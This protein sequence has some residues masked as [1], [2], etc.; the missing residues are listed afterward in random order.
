MNLLVNN[1]IRQKLLE[2]PDCGKNA[3]MKSM[4]MNEQNGNWNIMNLLVNNII[5]QKL[6][7]IPDRGTKNTMKSTKMKIQ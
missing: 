3:T 2:M 1:I 4:K 6:L 5:L 7:E